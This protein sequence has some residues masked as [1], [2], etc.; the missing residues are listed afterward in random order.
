M[1]RSV[2]R[3]KRIYE[4]VGPD[5]GRRVL[6]DRLWPRGISRQGAALDLWLPDVA[7]STELRKWFGHADELWDR[8]KVRYEEELRDSPHLLTLCGLAHDGPLTLLYG[9][10]NEAHNQAAVLQ[11]ILNEL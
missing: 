1:T 5:D 7:P 3:I 8:F 10:K 4:P 11:E 9:A 6:V 2:V